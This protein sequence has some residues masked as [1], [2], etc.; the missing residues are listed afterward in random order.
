MEAKTAPESVQKSFFFTLCRQEAPRGTQDAPRWPQ[1]TP[2]TAHS[3]SKTLPRRPQNGPWRPQEAPKT[4]Q[5]APGTAQDGPRPPRYPPLLPGTGS[6][7][8]ERVNPPL[9]PTRDCVCFL[10]PLFFRYLLSSLLMSS[11]V[12]YN[13]LSLSRYIWSRGPCI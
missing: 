3:G 9:P 8:T 10:A 12:L 7:L 11:T 5:D 6:L 2:R 1:E 4:A 13:A